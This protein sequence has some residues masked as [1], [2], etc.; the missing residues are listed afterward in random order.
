MSTFEVQDFAALRLREHDG[1]VLAAHGDDWSSFWQAVRA[2][3]RADG[4]RSGTLR[5]YRQVLRDLRKF[6]AEQHGSSRPADLTTGSARA[7]M[8]FLCLK[9][10]SWSWMATVI[11]VLRNCFDRLGGLH[12]T[13]EMV[14]PRRKWP[15]PETLSE[16][17]LRLLF[18]ALAG[19]RDRLLAALLAG[20]GL[21]ISEACRVRWMDFDRTAKVLRLEDPSGLRSRSVNV[22]PGLLPM[23]E[24]LAAVSRSSDPM[25]CGPRASEGGPRALSARQ[26]E[27]LI[28]SAAQR[29]GILKRVTPTALRHTYA[30]RR[31]IA[32]DNIREIQDALGHHS[33]ETTMRYQACLPP[34]AISPADPVPVESTIREVTEQLRRLTEMAPSSP[35]AAPI[36]AATRQTGAAANPTP[37]PTTA[38]LPARTNAA[39]QPSAIARTV[40]RGP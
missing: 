6:L 9:N 29:T 16:R 28:K 3:L 32:G 34:K 11:A 22:P 1:L 24:G 37:T 12:V 8:E 10:V 33:L 20:C 25:I 17:E 40:P 4:Y 23:F 5:V 13:S 14:T 2:R 35:I 39:R 36:T 30:L 19:P 21:R 18:D 38:T 27:R 26:A 31:L 15:L 7:Y